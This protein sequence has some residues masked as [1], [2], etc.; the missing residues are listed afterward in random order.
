PY[1]A[2]YRLDVAAFVLLACHLLVALSIFSYDPTE[3]AGSWPD[4]P[5]TT[6]NLLGPAGA[7]MARQLIETLGVSVYILLTSWFVL[8]VLLFLRQSWWVWARRLC[9]WL[10]LLP[11]AAVIADWLGP[12]ACGGPLTGSGGRLGAC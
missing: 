11:C 6:S 1:P 2:G 9:G 12:N 3:L 4:N 10:L 5:A 7:F 8:V